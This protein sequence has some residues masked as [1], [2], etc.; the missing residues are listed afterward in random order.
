[1]WGVI[2]Y[3]GINISK[4][5]RI[6]M[7]KV[8]LPFILAVLLVVPASAYEGSAEPHYVDIVP[9]GEVIDATDIIPITDDMDE[10]FWGGVVPV[11]EDDIERHP[12]ARDGEEEEE[13]DNNRE[14]MIWIVGGA[15]IVIL[16]LG[17]IFSRKK[18]K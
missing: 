3:T 4:R 13:E 12:L 6:I 7:K 18:R 9:V 1:M 10:D 5:V 15:A 14:L 8:I 17:L 16:I 11:S 2:S